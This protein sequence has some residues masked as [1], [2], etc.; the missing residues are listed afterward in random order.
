[1]SDSARRLD[2]PPGPGGVRGLVDNFD[3]GRI[4]GWA[5]NPARPE[6][7]V[8]VTLRLDGEAVAETVAA[9]ERADLRAAGVGDGRHAFDLVVPPEVAARRAELSVTARAEDGRETRLPIRAARR[10]PA[11]SAVPSGTATGPRAPD[12]HPDGPPD[13]HP[14]GAAES[15]TAL[16]ERVEALAASVPRGGIAAADD[17]AALR[18][19]VETL[20]AW[21][22]RLDERLAAAPAAVRAPR[23]GPDRWQAVLGVVLL[24]L[25]AAALAVTWIGPAALVARVA[26]TRG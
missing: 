4:Y 24:L 26:A 16:R 10:P 20:E 8:R 18:E 13:G 14:N 12:G 5:W 9:A 25:G 17:L 15:G 1:M 22:L 11:L 3:G 19:R 23:R 2:T 6:E 21:C 7:R